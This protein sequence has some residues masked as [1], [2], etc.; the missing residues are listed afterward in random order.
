MSNPVGT[1]GAEFSLQRSM[2]RKDDFEPDCVFT[3]CPNKQGRG[4]W[5][6]LTIT[7]ARVGIQPV[8]E[9]HWKAL[10]FVPSPAVNQPLVAASEAR[11]DA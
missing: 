4:T 9:Q 11:P 10:R 5:T 8:C 6:D 1:P 2:P 7:G 3:F